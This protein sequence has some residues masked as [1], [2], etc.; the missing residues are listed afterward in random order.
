MSWFRAAFS[1]TLER[2]HNKEIGLLLPASSKSPS[3]KIGDTSAIF[4]SS[5]NVLVISEVFIIEVMEG[6]IT[7][8]ESLMTRAGNLSIPGA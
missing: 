7:G 4:Q 8:A 2:I 6:M 5:G 1:H 3:F